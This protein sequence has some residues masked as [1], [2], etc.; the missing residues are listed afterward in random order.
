MFGSLGDFDALIE[1]RMSLGDQGHDRSGAVAHLGRAPLVPGQPRQPR[2]ARRDWYVWADA[3]PDGTP[4]NNWLS[5]FGG[6]AWEWDGGRMQYYL[7]N[8]LTQQPDLNLHTPDV[9]DA[10]LDVERFWLN[11][12][13]R[14][15]PRHNQLLFPR[16]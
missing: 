13:G 6:S 16:R 8:F 14:L 11:G 10:L 3:K 4:P 12:G 1:R 7:H 9:Q 5:I 15:P 2:R